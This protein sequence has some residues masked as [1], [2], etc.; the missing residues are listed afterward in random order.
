MHRYL[1]ARYAAYRSVMSWELFNEADG[2]LGVLPGLINPW[3]RDA[4]DRLRELDPAGH[5]VSTS[6][7]S[8]IKL[9]TMEATSYD[10]NNRHQYALGAWAIGLQI[11]AYHAAARPLLLAEFGIDWEGFFNDRD[12][13]GLNI[14]NAVWSALFYGYAGGAMSWWW[15]N[16][17]DPQ[18]LWPLNEAPAA[19]LADESLNRKPVYELNRELPEDTSVV[20]VLRTGTFL[21][22]RE[23]VILQTGDEVLVITRQRNLAELTRHYTPTG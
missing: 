4:R 9:P 3:M 2:I 11:K 10:F 13:L 1:V 12:P 8:P 22:A 7:A 21:P 6:Y 18:N 15:D 16:Y 14:H 20:V 5:L 17:V 23:E 19:F